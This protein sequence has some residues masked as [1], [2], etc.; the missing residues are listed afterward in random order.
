MRAD[1]ENAHLAIFHNIADRVQLRSVQ[2]VLEFTAFQ[3]LSC[4]RE[5]KSREMENWIS[6]QLNPV[7]AHIKG[8]VKIMPYIKVFIIAN[9]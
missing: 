2:V 5:G 6:L 1:V 4:I 9:I 8:L 3:I 7:I